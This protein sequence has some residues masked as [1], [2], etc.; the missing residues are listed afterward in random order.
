MSVISRARQERRIRPRSY[1]DGRA[2]RLGDA[3]HL[4]A[5][6]RPLHN[7]FPHALSRIHRSLYRAAGVDQLC[8]TTAFHRPAL[9]SACRDAFAQG[10]SDPARI[11][12]ADALAARCRHGQFRPRPWQSDERSE[13]TFLY[14]GS[15]VSREKNIK[16]FLDLDL[17]GRKV[18]VGDGPLLPTLRKRYPRVY[19]KG[20]K[21]GKS[22]RLNTAA[23]DVF[24]FPSRTDTFGLVLLEAMAS[25]LPIAAYPVTGPIDVIT[26]GVTG[27][28]SEDLRAAALAALSLDRT[29]GSRRGDAARLVTRRRCLPQ[30]YLRARRAAGFGKSVTSRPR[31]NRRK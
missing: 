23:A 9:A 7:V 2:D 5:P 26:E 12:A 29:R 27:V 3:I 1:R 20:A 24:V 21:V 8:R 13:P 16:A 19:F 4:L 28:L 18:V 10:R 11:R 25:G 30:Q 6:R 15:R 31:I 22:L 14:V 17:P